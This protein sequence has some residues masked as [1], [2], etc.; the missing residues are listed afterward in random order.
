MRGCGRPCLS[1]RCRS[2]TFNSATSSKWWAD[3][4]SLL[5]QAMIAFLLALALPCG[6]SFHLQW[7]ASHESTFPATRFAAIAQV[8]SGCSMNPRLRGHAREIGRFQIQPVVARHRCPAL[9]VRTYRGNVACALRILEENMWRDRKSTRLNSS[10]PS[11]SYAVFCLKK[12]NH[13]H[14]QR[15]HLTA[16]K[17]KTQTKPL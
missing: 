3:G 7:E 1:S 8:E 12:K 6:D 17:T 14:T 4:R 13:P 11:I 5:S 9:N 2:S 10:H 16:N 15:I